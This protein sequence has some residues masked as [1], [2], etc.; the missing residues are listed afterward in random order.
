MIPDFPRFKLL[1]L[2][3]ADAI[4]ALS[5][6]LP[7]YSD[8]NFTSLWVW[9][10]AQGRHE[11]SVLHDN[12]VVRFTDY[13]T[14][15]PFYSFL[16]VHDTL[17]TARALLEFSAAMGLP[18]ELHLIPESATQMLG[19]DPLS[20]CEDQSSSDYVYLASQLSELL[21]GAYK[22]KRSALRA[23]ESEHTDRS[24]SFLSLR[25]PEA[26]Q[27][28]RNIT[29]AW[30]KLKNA[31]GVGPGIAHELEA[32]ELTIELAH[33]REYWVG[34]VS[35]GG[36]ATSF[37]VE[38]LTHGTWSVSHFAKSA[39]RRRGEN[40]YL[41]REIAARFVKQEVSHLNWQQDLGIESLRASKLSFR[42]HKMLKKFILA[43]AARGDIRS[44]L[45]PRSMKPPSHW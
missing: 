23:F 32:I 31:D 35:T 28:V 3:D 27:T 8:Y 20:S 16:G 13:L 15:E 9:G 17:Q 41:T 22:S 7:P 14:G 42:P 40:E 38:E 6:A 34:I 5:R 10:G 26:Q 11:I 21:G 45:R 25:D 43:P 36:V 12:L 2:E 29:Q 24:F 37:S 19:S 18:A 44:S 39:E 33:L 1:C 30:M 4:A